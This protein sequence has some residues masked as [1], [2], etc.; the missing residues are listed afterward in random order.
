MEPKGA[1]L[2]RKNRGV[3]KIEQSFITAKSLLH[4]VCMDTKKIAWFVCTEDV[5][6]STAGS[7]I[8]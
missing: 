7:P 3:K 4:K 1:F 6:F 5:R 2:L 8:L